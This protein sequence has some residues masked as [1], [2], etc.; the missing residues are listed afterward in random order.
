M[1]KGHP[2]VYLKSNQ[3]QLLK[4]EPDSLLL[5]FF[6]RVT[7]GRFPSHYSWAEGFVGPSVD[8]YIPLSV[9]KAQGKSTTGTLST[10][11]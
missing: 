11:R 7:M 4:E 10:E 3:T 2:T 5:F 1:M 9:P 6:Y 8:R